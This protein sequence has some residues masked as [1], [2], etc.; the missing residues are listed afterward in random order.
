VAVAGTMGPALRA[1]F[2][3]QQVATQAPCTL[4]LVDACGGRQLDDLVELFAAA[5]FVV[6]EIRRLGDQADH[7]LTSDDETH[8]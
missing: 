7:A 5:G 6:Q 1:A 3:A 4:L 2:P 8:P